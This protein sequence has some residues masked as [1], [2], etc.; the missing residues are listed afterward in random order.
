MTKSDAQL[1]FDKTLEA[2]ALCWA[3]AMKDNARLRA[4]LEWY[5]DP[6]SWEQENPEQYDRG[7]CARAALKGTDG[8]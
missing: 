5:A 7:E 4:A 6:S 3:E 1:R 8:E 2:L